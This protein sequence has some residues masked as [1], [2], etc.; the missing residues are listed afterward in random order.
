MV[1]ILRVRKRW[2]V[3]IAMVSV[4][5]ITLG[6]LSACSTSAPPDEIGLYYKKGPF[7]GYHFDHCFDPATKTSYTW[8]NEA[9]F[10]PASFRTWNIAPEGT[11]NVDSHRP[12]IVNS[13]PEEN[14]PSGVQVSLW[15]QFAFTLNVDC[16]DDNKDANS[17]IV[18][19]WENIGRRYWVADTSEGKVDWWRTMLENTIVPAA[20]TA[21]RSVAR[22]YSA[23]VIVAN[24]EREVIQD[25]ITDRLNT[26]LRRIGL[27]E[28][29]CGPTYDPRSPSAECGG[30]AVLLKDTDYT[31]PAIQAARDQKQASIEQAAADLIAA[32]GEAAAAQA[33][34]QGQAEAAAKLALLY[35][36]P[37]WVRLEEM[38]LAAEACKAAAACTMVVG[39]DGTVISGR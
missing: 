38:R 19:W 6:T 33:R 1:S 3:L 20:E 24:T 25:R 34:A 7:D 22:E 15:P 35:S 9:I 23:D 28:F 13:A 8:N 32:Q 31:N 10:L 26:E 16:G 27:D 29:Y 37:E 4:A 30:V 36:N 5:L 21:S 39:A 11:P 18:R 14:Q 17:P 2:T 12:I